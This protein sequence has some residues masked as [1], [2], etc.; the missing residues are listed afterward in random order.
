M[1]HFHF[2]S[3]KQLPSNFTATFDL[4]I[5]V[6]F[7]AGL[8]YDVS[9]ELM[10]SPAK[11]LNFHAKDLSPPISVVKHLK[12]VEKLNNFVIHYHANHFYQ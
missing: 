12:T 9:G 10:V 8:L 11:H 3:F 2:S 4:R 7:G 6:N 1:I 5:K